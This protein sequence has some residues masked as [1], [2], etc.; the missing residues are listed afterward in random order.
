[1]EPTT[2]EWYGTTKHLRDHQPNL[3]GLKKPQMH[4]T[5]KENWSDQNS[6]AKR[7]NHALKKNPNLQLWSLR[8]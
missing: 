3:A 1:M 2:F 4:N 6:K 8:E 7:M 5:G